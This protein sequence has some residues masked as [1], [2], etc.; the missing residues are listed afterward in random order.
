MLR[1]LLIGVGL[2]MLA[3]PVHGANWLR[4]CQGTTSAT[5]NKANLSPGS[6][7]CT[8]PTA[9]DEESGLAW[10]GACE[11]SDIMYFSDKDGDGTDSGSGVEVY[12]CPSE[13]GG[14]N[15]IVSATVIAACQQVTTT[16]LTGVAPAEAIY[17]AKLGW[18]YVTTDSTAAGANGDDMEIQVWCNGP[19]Q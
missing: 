5:S 10:G 19:S 2:L 17:G 9:A 8:R 14:A 11:N 3:S 18:F 4:A 13:L 1:T 6:F 16:T 15:T 12:N 7:A